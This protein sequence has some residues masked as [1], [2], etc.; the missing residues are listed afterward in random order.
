ML[1]VQGEPVTR[2]KW[3][4]DDRN[5]MNQLIPVFVDELVEN[6]GVDVVDSDEPRNA[7]SE[8]TI[9]ERVL[10]L[11]PGLTISLRD[12]FTVYG[13]RYGVEGYAPP[14][15][16]FFTSAVFRTEVKLKRVTG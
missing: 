14:V 13:I 10:F 9:V 12:Q 2:H 1:Q 15:R 7:I 8:R 4:R 3:L 5:A 6:V 11:P 16:N